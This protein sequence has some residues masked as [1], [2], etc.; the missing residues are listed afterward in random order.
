MRLFVVPDD[1]LLLIGSR[2]IEAHFSCLGL[3]S[4]GKWESLSVIAGLRYKTHNRYLSLSTD[5]RVSCIYISFLKQH[6]KFS[7]AGPR[8]AWGVRRKRLAVAA[9]RPQVRFAAQQQIAVTLI[10]LGQLTLNLYKM[11]LRAKG[12]DILYYG[13]IYTP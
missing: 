11:E 5:L 10:T 7:G 12:R 13:C 9:K 1:G 3:R 2:S 6:R 8:Q 4:F